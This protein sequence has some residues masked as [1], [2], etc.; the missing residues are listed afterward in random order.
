MAPPQQYFAE[1]IT[2]A[3][4]QTH[5]EL[6][7]RV[8]LATTFA[9]W[10]LE[11]RAAD[12]PTVR[13]LPFSLWAVVP[14]VHLLVLH[15]LAVHMLR[16][17]CCQP[18]LDDDEPHHGRDSSMKSPPERYKHSPDRWRRRR[19]Y[20]HAP[21]PSGRPAA[22]R[23]AP[24]LDPGRSRD[25]EGLSPHKA[26]GCTQ[27]ES[28]GSEFWCG[29]RLCS[30]PPHYCQ[31]SDNQP[32]DNSRSCFCFAPWPDRRCP[33]TSVPC[34]AG[35]DHAGQTSRPNFPRSCRPSG[36]PNQGRRAAVAA[37]PKI[38]SRRRPQ[39]PVPMMTV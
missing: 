5:S 29:A 32:S 26:E 16:S 33:L 24:A 14:R 28:G 25:G 31:H 27:S 15:P 13:L 17:N 3:Q 37:T 35:L 2:A 23:P 1:V 19:H 22:R 34:I 10:V 4:A 12:K 39:P 7:Q 36:P 30:N 21:S 20:H 18:Q 9:N 6:P 8:A 38:G 11:N